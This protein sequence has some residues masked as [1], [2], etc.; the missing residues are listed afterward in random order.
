MYNLG[1]GNIGCA[2]IQQF[3]LPNG[4]QVWLCGI[5]CTGVTTDFWVEDMDGNI[6]FQF[7]AQD[8]FYRYVKDTDFNPLKN[9]FIKYVIEEIQ[10]GY[11][12][13]GQRD[14]N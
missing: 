13:G 12:N 8:L 11:T 10:K 14:T 4:R 7:P 9:T 1:Y 5:P 3:E 6:L 2:N